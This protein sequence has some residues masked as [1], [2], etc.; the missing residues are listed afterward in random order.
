MSIS[1]YDTTSL[2]P[3]GAM[4]LSTIE[5]LEEAS[6]A[7]CSGGRLLQSDW[8]PQWSCSECPWHPTPSPMPGQGLKFEHM[9]LNVANSRV[10]T[11]RDSITVLQNTI[12]YYTQQVN[13]EQCLHHPCYCYDAQGKSFKLQS[14]AGFK[15]NICSSVF[16]TACR[17]LRAC[18]DIFSWVGFKPG[19]LPKWMKPLSAVLN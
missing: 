8:W 18:T 3:K 11:L 12:A 10:V 15:D 9:A 16:K 7:S 2:V 6:A 14:T 5:C 1:P 19:L 17:L 4:Y 13:P